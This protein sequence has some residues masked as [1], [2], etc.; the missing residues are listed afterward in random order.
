MALKTSYA[1]SQW[2]RDFSPL[3]HFQHLGMHSRRIETKQNMHTYLNAYSYYWDF[4]VRSNVLNLPINGNDVFF[5]SFL[6]SHTNHSNHIF[7]TRVFDFGSIVISAFGVLIYIVYSRYTCLFDQPLKYGNSW[8]I[9]WVRPNMMVK[10]QQNI[11]CNTQHTKCTVRLQENA[12]SGA[13]LHLPIPNLYLLKKHVY[14]HS[15]YK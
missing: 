14:Q 13:K 11:A 3:S 9:R 15:T 8:E 1:N 12:S 10:Q 4:R 2:K 5:S 7:F 6:N